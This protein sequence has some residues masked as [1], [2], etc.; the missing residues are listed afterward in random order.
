MIRR[1]KEA[2]KKRIFPKEI[3]NP[4]ENWLLVNKIGKED[5]NKIIIYYAP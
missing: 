4:P 5:I 3:D 2:N 1:L